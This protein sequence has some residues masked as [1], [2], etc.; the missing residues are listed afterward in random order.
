LSSG[1]Q[2]KAIAASDWGMIDVCTTL[3]APRVT[4][5]LAGWSPAF[6]TAAANVNPLQTG[7]SVTVG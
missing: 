2:G 1:T 3:E 5:M 4:V 6:A 7:L